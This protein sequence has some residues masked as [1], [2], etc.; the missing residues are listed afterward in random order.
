MDYNLHLICRDCRE[1]PANLVEEY[2]SGDYVCGSCGLVLG[3]IVDERSEWRTFNNEN[4]GSRGSDPNRVGDASNPYLAGNQ[5]YTFI[6]GGDKAA[7]SALTL[8]NSATNLNAIN[9]ALLPSY[10]QIEALCAG[11]GLPET[12]TNCAKQLYR[13]SLEKKYFAGKRV[14]PIHVISACI[15]I[16]CRLCSYPR[17]FKEIQVLTCV[18]KVDIG[19]AFR[20][21]DLKFKCDNPHLEMGGGEIREYNAGSTGAADL[22]PR[23]CSLLDLPKYSVSFAQDVARRYSRDVAVEG[24]S[25]MSIAVAVVFWVSNITGTPRTIRQISSL[26]ST[27]SGMPT[28]PNSFL[29]LSCFV[30]QKTNPLQPNIVLYVANRQRQIPP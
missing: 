29:F 16:A 30:V 2:S 10:A 25:P 12:V 9:K 28:S 11:C 13:I 15:H 21:L 20:K 7:S 8:A 27:S 22:M 18:D 6:G 4:E 14:P 23:Y 26:F 19:R 1:E 17:A 3:Q 24:K 5:L